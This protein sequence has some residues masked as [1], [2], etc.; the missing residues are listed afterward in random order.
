M[1]VELNLARP[2][3]EFVVVQNGAYAEL[4]AKLGVILD[5]LGHGLE[6]LTWVALEE[7]RFECIVRLAAHLACKHRCARA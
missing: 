1:L 6:F 4:A 7:R 5:N 2:D 3:V